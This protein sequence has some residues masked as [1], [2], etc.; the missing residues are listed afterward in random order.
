MILPERKMNELIYEE[1]VFTEKNEIQNI[2]LIDEKIV[3]IYLNSEEIL[4]VMTICDYPE[5]LAVGFLYNQN[6]INSAEDLKEVE[7]NEELSVVVVRTKNVTPFEINNRKRIKT[8]G[9]AMG[10]V[11]G[12]MF[13]NL[14]PIDSPAFF[15]IFVKA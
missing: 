10:T 6:L 5:Y 3:T 11:F 12:E 1:K 9:C 8:S 15:K 7:F 14:V 13:D 4:T 2:S